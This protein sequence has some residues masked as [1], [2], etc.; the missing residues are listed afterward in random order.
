[1]RA[2]S[3]TLLLTIT[4]SFLSYQLSLALPRLKKLPLPTSQVIVKYDAFSRGTPYES[5]Y[6]TAFNKSDKYLLAKFLVNPSLPANT[7]VEIFVTLESKRWTYVY[8][9]PPGFY[10]DRRV[11]RHSPSCVLVRPLYG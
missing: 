2:F 9:W 1:M 11:R 5:E 3:A 6:C 7:A 10:T 4:I 8:G